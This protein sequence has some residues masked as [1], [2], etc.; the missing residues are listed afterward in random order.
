[1]HK[2]EFESVSPGEDSFDM[3][4]KLEVNWFLKAKHEE[5]VMTAEF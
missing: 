5:N 2:S 4:L 3:T 1:M